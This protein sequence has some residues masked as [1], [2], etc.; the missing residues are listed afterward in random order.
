MA[1]LGS[2]LSLIAVLICKK[3]SDFESWGW[4]LPF[5]FSLV[6]GL[7]SIYTR[8]ILDESQE[9]KKQKIH[10]NCC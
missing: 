7:I 9:Y 8:Y 5:V 3:V 6:M 2:I 10:L 4:R 1:I